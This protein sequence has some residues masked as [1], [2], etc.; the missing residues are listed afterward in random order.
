MEV[1]HPVETGRKRWTHYLFEFF[2]LFLAV[3]CGFL[4]EYQLE[5]KIE[6]EKEQQLIQSLKLDLA[7]DISQIDSLSR[8]MNVKLTKLDLLSRG[9]YEGV[10]KGVS[11]ST[12]KLILPAI[13]F[14]DF[15]YTDK[16]ISQLKNAGGMRLIRNQK[17]ADSIAAYDALV[18]RSLVN[19]TGINETVSP[20]L[21][22]SLRMNTDFFMLQKSIS[23]DLN[24]SDTM[25]IKRN[26]FI[27]TDKKQY[28]RLSND[29]LYFRNRLFT[30]AKLLNRDKIGAE[31]LLDFLNK[32]YR[33]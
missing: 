32:E 18:R 20:S 28:I 5:H 9:L 13:G 29:I 7:T 4:A 33:N 10:N 1:H 31:R 25:M 12:I 21:T 15:I 23:P 2:M 19:Q 24:L 22:G 6:R 3:F 8:E 17:I 14:N 27:F 16:T 30:L 11:F 26:A